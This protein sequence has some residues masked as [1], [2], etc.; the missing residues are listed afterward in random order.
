MSQGKKDKPLANLSDL[1][2]QLDDLFARIEKEEP[3]TVQ[4]EKT[5]APPP[6]FLEKSAQATQQN[7]EA[8]PKPAATTEPAPTATASAEEE[9]PNVP[10]DEAERIMLEQLAASNPDIAQAIETEEAAATPEPT[11]KAAPAPAAAAPSEDSPNVPED[12]AERIMLEQLAASNPD[13][14]QAIETEEAAAAPEPTPKAEPAPNDLAA[15]L[16]AAATDAVNEV[17]DSKPKAPENAPPKPAAPPM[18]DLA[19]QLLA[20][21]NAA[22][23]EL[24]TDTK[25]EPQAAPTAAQPTLTTPDSTLP[26]EDS[27]NVPEDEAERIMLEQLAA[28]NPD[29]AAI[30][31]QDEIN[32]AAAAEA[33][34]NAPPEPEQEPEEHDELLDPI[35]AQGGNADQD[36]IDS[37]I[38]TQIERTISAAD[39]TAPTE[40]PSAEP[41]AAAAQTAEPADTETELQGDFLAP[42]HLDIESERAIDPSSLIPPQ[43][44]TDL[45]SEVAEEDIAAIEENIEDELAGTFES[46][47]DLNIESS[48]PTKEEQ[49]TEEPASESFNLDQLAG[50][51]D[52][53]LSPNATEPET[54]AATAV[55]EEPTIDDLDDQLAGSFDTPEEILQPAATEEPTTEPQ[56]AAPDTTTVSI[57]DIDNII[58]D[59]ADQTLQESADPDKRVDEITSNVTENTPQPEATQQTVNA[60]S[61]PENFASPAELFGD[62]SD[63]PDTP[64][65]DTEAQP[66]AFTASAEDVAREL[67][68]DAQVS[69]ATATATAT[70]PAEHVSAAQSS[71]LDQDITLETP[72][73]K[74]YRASILIKLLGLINFPALKLNDEANQVIGW[75]AIVLFFTSACL[76]LYGLIF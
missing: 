50:K 4:T 72:E 54:S 24:Q 14:A 6:R 25:P 15:Q 12:E 59:E 28:T 56:A 16:L 7:R 37:L 41:V 44:D 1:G 19:A 76:C 18:S 17:N 58:A 60:E 20:Q 30:I 48:Q 8:T 43:E 11:P 69:P 22:V 75:T 68:Q 32:Q 31:E 23:S 13:I 21:A 26:E 71:D 9:S 57:E 39:T 73:A 66:A 33:V 62:A 47:A 40:S 45:A 53:L 55:A 51:L 63:V 67:D 49:P 5:S 65:E 42:E 35:A 10:E 70:A 3:G 61:K 74:P 52:S 64:E 38:D 27:P 46:P 29:V 36:F 34:K 2:N